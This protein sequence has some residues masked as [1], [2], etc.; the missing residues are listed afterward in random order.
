MA[1]EK[2]LVTG[3][4]G[5]VGGSL[6][7]K[8]ID[9]HINIRALTRDESSARRLRQA[10]IE[11]VVGDL[12]IPETLDAAFRGVDRVFLLTAPSPN[13]VAQARNAIAAA[14]RANNPHIVRMSAMLADSHSPARIGRQHAVIE[15]ELKASGLPYTILN[16][17]FFMQNT[18]MSASTVA[19]GCPGC[20]HGI[21]YMPLRDC[22]IGMIDVRDIAEVAATV[23]TDENGHEG[24]A[25][26]LTGPVSI[27]FHDVAAGLEKALG[28]EVVYVDVPVEAAKESMA[29]TWGVSDWFADA[30]GEYLTAFGKGMGDIVTDDVERVTGQPARSFE[31]F[32]RDFAPAFVRGAQANIA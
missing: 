1:Y 27:S 13:Q 31:T 3:A 12:E 16:P 15:A 30:I 29:A 17:H 26:T 7:V 8:L 18:M 10:G 32:A 6:I 20:K 5:T 22:K 11:A 24:K 2:I 9:M 23:L 14:G 25:Y 19:S 21:V 28:K 4:T